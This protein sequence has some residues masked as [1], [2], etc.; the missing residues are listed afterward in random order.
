MGIYYALSDN[1]LFYVFVL[2][3]ILVVVLVIKGIITKNSS[4]GS[5]TKDGM[6]SDFMK[7]MILMGDSQPQEP[8]KYEARKCPNCGAPIDPMSP[9][10]CNFCRTKFSD[11]TRDDKHAPIS[12][13][14]YNPTRYYDENFTGYSIRSGKGNGNNGG[15][16]NNGYN[17]NNSFSNNNGYNSNNGYGNNN[18]YN[19]NGSFG[20]YNGYNNDGSY[21][22]YD[23]DNSNN[24]YNGYHNSGRDDFDSY[25]NTHFN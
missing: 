10:Y 12:P 25:S 23:P 1:P 14:E 9:F 16:N 7:Y 19:N 22:S 4:I 18:G 11:T 2:I 15:Q 17:N 13:K 24:N 20:N 6:D 21:G 3:G 5:D 8:G